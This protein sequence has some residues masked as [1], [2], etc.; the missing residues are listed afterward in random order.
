MEETILFLSGSI[1]LLWISLPGLKNPKS[2]GYYRFFSWVAILAM[3]C[4]NM[5]YWFI[6]P[7]S[8]NQVIA[9]ILLIISLVLLIPGV[10]L[11]RTSGKPTDM[12]EATTRLVQTGIYR[13]IRHPLYA[14]LLFLSWGIFLKQPSLLEG[15][16]TMVTAAFLYATARADENESIAKFGQEYSNYMKNSRM[17]IPFL[18]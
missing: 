14:S 16:L 5:R 18:F 1:L 10:V 12:L 3:F 2:Y 8:W 4:L 13:Y 15:C 17:F 6:D 11:L 9:W 7:F